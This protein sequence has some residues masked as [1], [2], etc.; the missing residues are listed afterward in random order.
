MMVLKCPVGFSGDGLTKHIT[1][2]TQGVSVRTLQVSF[3]WEVMY[4]V[5]L[6]YSEKAVR[7][8]CV[9]LAVFGSYFGPYINK[10]IP[11][12]NICSNCV[13]FTSSGAFIAF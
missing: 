4:D 12:Y 11:L 7:G 3:P 2:N 8:P 10:K 5:S 1:W 6:L 9:K 13:N